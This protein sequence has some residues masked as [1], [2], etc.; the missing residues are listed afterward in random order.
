MYLRKI[1]SN[2]EVVS[3]M[4]TR[5]N[6]IKLYKQALEILQL[7]RSISNYLVQDLVSLQNDG[8]E[9][10]FIY[11]TGDIIRQSDSLAPGIIKAE[12]QIFQ[13]ERIKHALSLKRLTN[14]LY[15]NCER[16]EKSESNG[17]DFL[18]L[19]RKEL[20]KFKRLQNRWMTSL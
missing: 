10:P 18:I 14:H 19:L 16:L 7:S 20:K 3:A 12:S 1:K 4:E 11:F 8:R 6:T 17:K 15:T 5:P 13:D 9:N 2:F